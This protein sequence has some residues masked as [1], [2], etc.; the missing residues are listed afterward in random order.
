MGGRRRQHVDDEDEIVT[1]RRRGLPL[2]DEVEKKLQEIIGKVGDKNTG[3]SI[4]S[5]LEGLCR[6]LQD[7]LDKYRA[8]IIDIIVGCAIYLP[9]KVTVYTTL[10]GL[11]NAKNFNFGGDVVEK[12]IAEQQDLLE[13]E[14]Y[15]EAQNLTTFLCDLGNCR[16]LTIQSIGE[17]LESFITAAFEENVPQVRTDWFV[18]TVLRSL[19]FIGSELAEKANEQLENVFGGIEKYLEQRSKTHVPILQVWRPDGTPHEQEDYLDSLY[20]QI[21]VLRE[22]E[23]KEKHIPRH[24]V[25]FDAVLQDALQHNLPSFSPPAHTEN[26][27]YPYPRVVFRIFDYADCPEDGTVLPGTHAIERFL[28]EMEI[29]WIIEKNCLSR[30]HCAKELVQFAQENPTIPMGYLMFETIFAQ[31]FR[32]PQS[33][34]PQIFYASLLL[35]LC[36]LQATSYPQILVQSV[37]LLYQRADAMQPACIDRLVDWFSFHLSNFQYRYSW[38]DWSD[39]IEKDSFCGSV[40]FAREVIEKCRRLG[41]YDKIIQALPSEFVRIHPTIPEIRYMLDDELEPGYHKATVFTKMFQERRDADAFLEE[42]QHEDP[43]EGYNAD[44]FAVFVTVMLKMAAKTYS[45]N[46]SALSRYQKTLKTVCDFHEKFQE[47]LLDTIYSCWKT[48]QQMMMIL[49][50]KLLKMQ[51]LDCSQVISWLFDEKLKCEHDRQW[52]FEVLNTALEK[53]SRHIVSVEKDYKELKEKIEREKTENNDEEMED[54][55]KKAAD[56]EELESQKEKLESLVDFQKNLF[57]DV[58]HKFTVALTDII[59]KCESEGTDFHT[60]MFNWVRGRYCQVFLWHCRT[61]SKFSG[62]LSDELF[63]EGTD[64]RVLECFKQFLALRQ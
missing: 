11:L 36:R 21:S 58:L 55:D 43:E 2:V 16:V 27:T 30:K 62:P 42:L 64:D 3:S 12:L 1:K 35:E 37:E 41:S 54:E 48:N 6:V 15:C 19:P 33:P 28:I 8:T 56:L 40:A 26:S 57:M 29:D 44:D 25:G 14:K 22:A 45:H 38:K 32:L 52:T 53:L 34:H 63:T 10:V 23:W 18:F 20:A 39:C 59:V 4:E 50:D 13:N 51:V 61:L 17:Y 47:V 9:N 5:N 31:L 24:Y 49:I 7:D 46:F 60:P